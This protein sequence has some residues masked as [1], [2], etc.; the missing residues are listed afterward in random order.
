M[1]YTQ[2][3]FAQG[4]SSLELEEIWGCVDPSLVTA[5]SGTLRMGGNGYGVTFPRDRD[6]TQQNLKFHTPAMYH[7]PKPCNLLVFTAK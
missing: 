2:C 4:Q 6:F 5:L 7:N 3:I 1:S